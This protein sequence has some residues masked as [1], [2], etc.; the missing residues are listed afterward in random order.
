MAIKN[1]GGGSSG[2]S[3]N[4]LAEALKDLRRFYTQSARPDI[5]VQSFSKTHS[6]PPNSKALSTDDYI[7]YYKDRENLPHP[8]S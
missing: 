1:I 5:I 8:T 4:K 2:G 7:D 6:H 3:P